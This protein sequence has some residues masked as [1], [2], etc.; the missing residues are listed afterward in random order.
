MISSLEELQL[1]YFTHWKKLTGS[2]QFIAPSALAP[3]E[4]RNRICIINFLR[5]PNGGANA[6]VCKQV[7]GRI[8]TYGTLAGRSHVESEC[9]DKYGLWINFVVYIY[10]ILFLSYFYLH[11]WMPVLHILYNIDYVTQELIK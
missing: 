7:P 1:P 5:T 3:L 6:T 4:A 2:L 11:S 10:I 9:F 8:D